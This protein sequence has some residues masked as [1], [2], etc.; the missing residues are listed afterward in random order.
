LSFRGRY[1]KLVSEIDTLGKELEKAFAAL[2]LAR[3][4]KLTL[5]EVNQ[6]K[7]KLKNQPVIEKHYYHGGSGC[8]IC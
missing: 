1:K 2:Q 4:N 8:I 7:E 6:L 3:Q 5:E